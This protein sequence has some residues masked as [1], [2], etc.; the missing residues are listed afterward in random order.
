M[1]AT[2]WKEQEED[3]TSYPRFE[4]L[5]ADISTRLIKMNP[6]DVDAEI[7]GA[8]KKIDEFFDANMCGLFRVTPWAKELLL[9]HMAV[10]A[11][12]RVLLPKTDYAPRSPWRFK[13]VL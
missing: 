12:V 7:D 8:L 11:D 10:S 9:T 5:L 13:K 3:A 6:R 2:E 1:A 4:V